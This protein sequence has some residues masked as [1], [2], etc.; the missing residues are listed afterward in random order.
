[1][2]ALSNSLG[3][4]WQ[5]V[6]SHTS[7]PLS[8]CLM[9]IMDTKVVPGQTAGI[10]QAGTAGVEVAK[11]GGHT[12]NQM[13]HIIAPD[14]RMAVA[15]AAMFSSQMEMLRRT[16]SSQRQGLPSVPLWELRY[17]RPPQAPLQHQ[18]LPQLQLHHLIVAPKRSRPQRSL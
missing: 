4:N 7:T 2:T 18:V 10:Q 15:I 16:H 13:E 9:A 5:M 6:M 11:Q 14:Q 8:T 1:V 12:A 3:P 17:S